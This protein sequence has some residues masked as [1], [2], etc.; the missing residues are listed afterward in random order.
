MSVTGRHFTTGTVTVDECGIIVVSHTV[1]VSVIG[2]RDHL[3]YRDVVRLH[4]N[5]GDALVHRPA[6]HA[7]D[8]PHGTVTVSCTGLNFVRVRWT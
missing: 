7:I 4:L 1:T 3:G 5:V 2:L 6:R 8:L